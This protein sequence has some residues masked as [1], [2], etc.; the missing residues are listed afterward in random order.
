MKVNT[1]L[2]RG[3][4]V[5]CGL[6]LEEVARMIG[7]ARGTFSRKM[8]SGALDF[9]IIELHTL[10]EVLGLTNEEAVKIFLCEE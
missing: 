10:Y 5:S 4:I 9:T 2:L 3:K 6:T 1:A 8:H 7:I